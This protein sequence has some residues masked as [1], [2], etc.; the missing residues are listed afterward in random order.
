[1]KKK[2][3]AAVIGLAHVHVGTLFKGLLAHPEV[4]FIG[5]C[6]TPAT[7]KQDNISAFCKIAGE[8]PYFENWRELA[9]KKPDIALVCCDNRQTKEIAVPLLDMGISVILEKPVAIDYAD[10][11]SIIDAAKRAGA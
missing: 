9:D 10:T 2:L 3:T 7:D 6:D 1:M 4:E 11:V 5:W 8:I